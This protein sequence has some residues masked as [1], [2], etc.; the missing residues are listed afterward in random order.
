MRSVR[1]LDSDFWASSGVLLGLLGAELPQDVNPKSFVVRGC[2]L[3]IKRLQQSS[4]YIPPQAV[5][6][7]SGLSAFNSIAF[8]DCDFNQRC[9]NCTGNESSIVFD[10]PVNLTTDRLSVIGNTFR[11]FSD[12]LDETWLGSNAEISSNSGFDLETLTDRII[13]DS[14]AFVQVPRLSGYFFQG[15]FSRPLRFVFLLSSLSSSRSRRSLSLSFPSVASAFAF[16]PSL[17]QKG[18]QR[19]WA[20]LFVMAFS[21][22]KR[23]F[24]LKIFWVS[25]ACLFLTFMLK[26]VGCL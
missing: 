16:F 7:G 22:F 15:S 21:L 11:G 6:I 24:H 26:I 3:S 20:S 8:A 23:L 13:T 17:L 18:F 5:R 14:Q 10:L 2:S 19:I 25:T 4:G 9:T 12:L 1:I